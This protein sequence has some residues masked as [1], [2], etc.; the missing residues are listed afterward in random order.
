MTQLIGS[1]ES[2]TAA[3]NDNGMG[4]RQLVIFH[5]LIYLF[6]GIDGNAIA[7]IAQLVLR[8]AAHGDWLQ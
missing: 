6:G 2:R 3:A 4:V 5:T 7:L 8:Q 1:H